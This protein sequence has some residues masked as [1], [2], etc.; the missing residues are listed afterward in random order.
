LTCQQAEFNSKILLEG[1]EEGKDEHNDFAQIYEG[2]GGG[3]GEGTI[4]STSPAS[5]TNKVKASACLGS[6]PVATATPAATP[7]AKGEALGGIVALGL[8]QLKQPALVV[9]G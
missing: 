9:G 4:E 1:N 3:I 5:T 7:A 6:S 8:K 2:A